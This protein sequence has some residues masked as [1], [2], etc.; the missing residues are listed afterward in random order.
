[1]FVWF[2]HKGLVGT[3][4]KQGKL[5]PCYAKLGGKLVGYL[6][7]CKQAYN[8]QNVQKVQDVLCDLQ[9]QASKLMPHAWR[10]FEDVVLTFDQQV[11]TPSG[12]ACKA[13]KK[14]LTHEEA[15]KACFVLEKSRRV[16]MR[17]DDDDEHAFQTMQAQTT[18]L[19]RRSFSGTVPCGMLVHGRLGYV[20]LNL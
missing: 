13:C 16:E 3:G 19:T 11:L 20:Y 18:V 2:G 15:S 5:L 14:D 17:W 6:Q 8:F 7:V 1:M 4:T 12:F 9:D 10:N